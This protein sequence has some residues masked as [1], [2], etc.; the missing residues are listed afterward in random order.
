MLHYPCFVRPGVLIL[1][2]PASLKAAAVMSLTALNTPPPS[3]ISV[4]DVVSALIPT[5]LRH[6]VSRDSAVTA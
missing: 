4:F 2:L 6:A 3:L 1:E 5:S